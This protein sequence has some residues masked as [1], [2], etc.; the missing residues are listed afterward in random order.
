MSRPFLREVRSEKSEEG[1]ENITG[2]MLKKVLEFCLAHELLADCDKLLVAVSG[3][4]DSVAL[5]Y[6]LKQLKDE[7][8]IGCE[9]FAG[10]VNHQL[11]GSSSDGDEEFVRN[12]AGELGIECVTRS[13]DVKKYAV[14]NR[15]SIETAARQVRIS[16]LMEMAD[17]H[18]CDRIA[19]AHHAD[20]NAETV[21]YRM[22]RGTGFKGLCGV[23]PETVFKLDAR[24]I[25]FVRPLLKV[26]KKEITVYCKENDIPWRHDHT[27][28]ELDY[29]RNRI[30]HLLIPYLQE[31][32]A[33]LTERLCKI[34]DNCQKLYDRIEQKIENHGQVFQQYG[35]GGVS[36]D[37]KIIK[38]LPPIVQAEVIRQAL[39]KVGCGLR[40][41]TR[42]HYRRIVSL[43]D[44]PGGK[45]IE[46]P[47][48][49]RAKM[50][51]GKILLYPPAES[52]D[53]TKYEE[54]VLEIKIPGIVEFGGYV[55]SA[56][57]LHPSECDL[58]EFIASKTCNI[59]WFDIDKINGSIHVRRRKTG[60]R[61]VPIGMAGEKK[62]GKFLTAEKVDYRLRNNIIIFEDDK[63]VIWVGPV[64][65]S[66]R[67]RVDGATKMIIELKTSFLGEK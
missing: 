34:S 35:R 50:E 27:N 21:I 58:K 8:A 59:E 9:L 22:M 49:F 66:D 14:E 46:L 62:I 63:Q 51:F 19:T 39:V 61:F 3:G 42:Q 53:D 28:D 45:V 20:D 2:S 10:H 5:L 43:L 7:G 33:A 1:I 67:T 18:D 13:V 64:R 25:T 17:S 40:F 41:I 48:R 44:G 16:C 65:A 6:A 60:D 52:T 36:V 15:L 31:N 37:G 30:R 57:L 4:A 47:G 26:T 32:C 24:T 12:F 29:T 56:K 54:E 38:T 11:R 23:N 55:I